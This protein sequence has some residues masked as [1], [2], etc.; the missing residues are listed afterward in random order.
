[1]LK[2]GGEFYIVDFGKLQN[3]LMHLIS[4]IMIHLEE[5]TDNINVLLPNILLK[6]VFSNV[7]IIDKFM[8]VFGT[9]CI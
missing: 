8:T 9:I 2:W 6:A 3:I 7:E 5:T 1:M 4:L